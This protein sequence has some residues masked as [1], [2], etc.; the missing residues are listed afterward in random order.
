[1][2]CLVQAV[3]LCLF[4]F[5]VCSLEYFFL[6][7]LSKSFSSKPHRGQDRFFRL[8]LNGF[9]FNGFSTDSFREQS[10][11]DACCITAVNHFTCFFGPSAPDGFSLVHQSVFAA[12]KQFAC[13]RTIFYSSQNL[14]N[15]LENVFFTSCGFLLSIN[16]RDLFTMMFS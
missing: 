5:R 1:M 3:V 4:R 2:V 6:A 10:P 8:H 9:S 16:V 7:D 13:W 15:L 12:S 14:H 11:F